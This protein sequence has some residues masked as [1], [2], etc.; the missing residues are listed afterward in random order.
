MDREYGAPE[1]AAFVRR[2]DFAPRGGLRR[3]FAR[4]A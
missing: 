1:A 4:E 3:A 2:L